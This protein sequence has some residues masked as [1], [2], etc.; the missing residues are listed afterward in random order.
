MINK[1]TQSSQSQFP[2]SAQSTVTTLEELKM[3][4]GKELGFHKQVETVTQISP[5][6]EKVAESETEN[7]VDEKPKP[8]PGK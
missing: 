6:S 5:Q 1:V 3:Q 8:K 4:H 2:S 7:E